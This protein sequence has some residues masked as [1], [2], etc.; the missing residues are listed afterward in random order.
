MFVSKLLETSRPDDEHVA[1]GTKVKALLYKNVKV[2]Y[3]HRKK[4]LEF[5]L[6]EYST[7]IPH[8]VLNNITGLSLNCL[9]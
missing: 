2:L 4:M 9:Y 7:K 1:I 3:R 8:S 6:F 5:L